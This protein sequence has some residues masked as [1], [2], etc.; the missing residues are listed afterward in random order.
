MAI[1]SFIAI[2]TPEMVRQKMAEVQSKLKVAGADVRWE[3]EEKFHATVKFLGNVEEKIL[4]TIL[5]AIEQSLKEFPSFII[6]YT[7]LGCFPN[8]HRPRVIWI[9]CVNQDGILGRIKETLDTILFPFGFK[10]ED[11]EFRPHITL[12]RVKSPKTIAS[13]TPILQSL[14]FEPE[15]STCKELLFMKSVLKPQGSEYTI[16]HRFPLEGS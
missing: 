16:M 4:P 5:L 11:R 3:P 10:R 14:T 6:T 15:T 12:G 9:G 2:E 7:T 1:R 8:L 13:L